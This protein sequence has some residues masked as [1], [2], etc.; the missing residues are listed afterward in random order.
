MFFWHA[1]VF[2]LLM[3][4]SL[5]IKRVDL[6]QLRGDLSLCG[7]VFCGYPEALLAAIAPAL[8]VIALAVPNFSG[9]S[10][11]SGL[12]KIAPDLC[13]TNKSNRG[14]ALRCHVVV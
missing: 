4:H 7:N 3:Q 11:P 2:R 6:E 10:V 14:F 5:N 12:A 9:V 1:L 13:N 8:A